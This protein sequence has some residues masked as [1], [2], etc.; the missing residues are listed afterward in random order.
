MEFCW[1]LESTWAGLW[2]RVRGLYGGSG[3]MRFMGGGWF[4]GCGFWL[5]GVGGLG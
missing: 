3:K 2:V 5:C 1:L 4:F